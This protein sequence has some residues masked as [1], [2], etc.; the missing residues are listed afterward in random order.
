MASA[1][2]RDVDLDRRYSDRAMSLAAS[3]ISILDDSNRPLSLISTS[4][5]TPRVNEVDRARQRSLATEILGPNHHLVFPKGSHAEPQSSYHLTGSSTLSDPA[6]SSSTGVITEPLPSPPE[7]GVTRS[8]SL[9][10]D[11]EKSI[12][13]PV[14]VSDSLG[15]AL[16]GLERT[17]S[18]S[19][20]MRGVKSPRLSMFI[21]DLEGVR[22]SRERLAAS[23]EES[24]TA[25]TVVDW[26]LRTPNASPEKI[27]DRS[28]VVS[29][30]ESSSTITETPQQ[31]ASIAKVTSAQARKDPRMSFLPKFL[32]AKSPVMAK[33]DL[34]IG[35]MKRA[36]TTEAGIAAEAE[37]SPHDEGKSPKSFFDDESSDGGNESTIESAQQAIVAS[38]VMVKNGSATKVGLKEMLS[39]IPPNAERGK[40]VKMLGGDLDDHGLRREGVNS[41]YEHQDAGASKD[42]PLGMGLWKEIDPFTTGTEQSSQHPRSISSPTPAPKAMRK[43]SFPPVAPLD[44]RAEHRFLR[45]SVVST[46][47]PSGDDK[48]QHKGRVSTPKTTSQRKLSRNIPQDSVLTLFIS[49]FHMSS[50]RAKEIVLPSPQNSFLAD[51]SEEKKPPTKATMVVE[52]DDERLFKFVRKEYASMRSTLR[53][54]SGAR[55]VQKIRLLSYRSE[56]QLIS[57]PAK[58]PFLHAREGGGDDLGAHMLSL[59]RKPRKGRKKF[60]CIQEIDFQIEEAEKTSTSNTEKMALEFVEDWS[61][62]KICFAVIAVLIS[63]LAATLLWI[64]LG[65]GED[66]LVFRDSYGTFARLHESDGRLKGAGDRVGSGAVLGLLVLFLGWTAVGSWIFLSWLVS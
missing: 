17:S 7:A 53:Q 55:S 24:S 59:F 13:S 23:G 2:A 39:S 22:D 35:Q 49:G 61:V 47:Y 25:T 51:D 6:V 42:G 10:T 12:S 4:S 33:R 38:P 27:L 54:L 60:K 52:V 40:T 1:S 44:V 11:L 5:Y 28:S 20:S 65:V 31:A 19:L 50:M 16:K 45:Q 8:R 30:S 26:P 21:E 62:S 9:S 37:N 3:R 43:V 29:P 63:S 15:F 48:G 34:D 36:G 66:T 41:L 56:S 14:A 32:R 58:P 57:K 18:P 46:P 64:F